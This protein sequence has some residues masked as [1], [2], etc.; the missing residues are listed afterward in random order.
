MAASSP[1]AGD[2]T[3]SCVRRSPKPNS[4][5]RSG[6]PM[7]VGSKKEPCASGKSSGCQSE[8]SKTNQGPWGER[9]RKIGGVP[10]VAKIGWSTLSPA[11]IVCSGPQNN[12]LPCQNA[13]PRAEGSARAF[14]I[15][16]SFP[17]RCAARSRVVAANAS[18][19]F[20][21]KFPPSFLVK[22]RPSSNC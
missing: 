17:R 12:S 10:A 20:I 18:C 9:P 14:A 11:K 7:K 4:V 1:S 8:M 5:G 21:R 13:I 22:H 15:S 3:A 2:R 16:P 6:W 19:C